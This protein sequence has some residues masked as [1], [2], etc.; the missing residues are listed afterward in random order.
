[1]K[2]LDFMLGSVAPAGSDEQVLKALHF[3]QAAHSGQ[4]RSE[5]T[6]YF[7]HVLDVGSRVAQ[8]TL[9]TEILQAAYLHDVVEDTDVTFDQLSKTFGSRVSTLV[10][11]LT[12]PGN[13]ME[14]SRDKSKRETYLNA[15]EEH[16]THCI[17]KGPIEATLIK[18][19]DK[20]SNSLSLRYSN[21]SNRACMGYLDTSLR[22]V[23]A[24]LWAFVQ[25]YL[26]ISNTYE[27]RRFRNEEELKELMANDPTMDHV[28]VLEYIFAARAALQRE[29]TMHMDHLVRGI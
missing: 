18:V 3:A 20:V 2:D 17:E 6:P 28:R 1:M 14:I 21:W 4:Q 22:V 23:T 9:D 25:E 5:G 29:R 12:L 10:A 8:L 11:W 26:E 7:F 27:L 19:A 13:L 16:Q 24:A 15:K